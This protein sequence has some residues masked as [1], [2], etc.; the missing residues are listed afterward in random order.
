MRETKESFFKPGS[1]AFSFEILHFQVGDGLAPIIIP[2][3]LRIFPGK[4]Y[5][6]FSFQFLHLLTFLNRFFKIRMLHVSSLHSY[7]MFQG[8]VGDSV[9]T[10]LHRILQSC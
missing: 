8:Q 3:N 5:K 1:L 4:L 10:T 2:T 9:H 6:S 7:Q